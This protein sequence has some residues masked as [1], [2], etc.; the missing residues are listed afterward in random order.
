MVVVAKV[1]RQ[2]QPCLGQWAEGGR[3]LLSQQAVR[4]VL[5]DRH[6]VRRDPPPVMWFHSLTKCL[7]TAHSQVWN[8]TSHTL[9]HASAP[10]L[11]SLPFV[12]SSS[13]QNTTLTPPRPAFLIAIFF[14][15]FSTLQTYT[16]V[17]SDPVAQ[18]LL[19]E[20]HWIELTL[21][22]WK[23]HLEVISY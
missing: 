19:S 1:E 7:H 14:I 23:A 22:E 2:S 5:P 18:C 4:V 21:A 9:T 16:S 3:A 12:P 10:E 11:T 15:G 13:N 8:T 20:V 17:S 6:S